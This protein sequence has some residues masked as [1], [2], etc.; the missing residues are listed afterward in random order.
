M[1]SHYEIKEMEIGHERNQPAREAAQGWNRS[2][3]MKQK[4]WEVLG[5]SQ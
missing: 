3:T 5:L 1:K 2:Q 4:F